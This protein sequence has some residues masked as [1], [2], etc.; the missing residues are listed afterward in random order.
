MCILCLLNCYGLQIILSYFIHLCPF[1][2]YL[3]GSVCRSD[4]TNYK[5]KGQRKL[6]ISKLCLPKFLIWI[7]CFDS[8]LFYM[9]DEAISYDYLLSHIYFIHAY[10]HFVLFISILIC[11]RIF[12]WYPYLH[13]FPLI[14]LMWVWWP[15]IRGKHPTLLAE[16]HCLY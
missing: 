2:L 4:A 14:S 16:H 15:S 12:F 9:Q 7:R 13:V 1:H 3:D 8:G 10:T 11:M 5:Q 6:G